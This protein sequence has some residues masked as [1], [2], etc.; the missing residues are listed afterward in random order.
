MEK[1]LEM[2]KKLCDQFEIYSSENNQRKY[3][4]RSNNDEN[5]GEIDTEQQVDKEIS[6][7]LDFYMG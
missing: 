5:D 6:H 1:L 2:A 4:N 7:P 3:Q